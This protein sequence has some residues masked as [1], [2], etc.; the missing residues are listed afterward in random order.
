MNGNDSE[1]VNWLIKNQKE[2]KKEKTKYF[3]IKFQLNIL[4]TNFSAI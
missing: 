4:P 2:N 3:L 1:L